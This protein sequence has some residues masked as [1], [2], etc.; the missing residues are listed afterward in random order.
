MIAA[1]VILIVNLGHFEGGRSLVNDVGYLLDVAFGAGVDE[2]GIP[3]GNFTSVAEG[4]G[5]ESGSDEESE[6]SEEHFEK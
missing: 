3:A 2:N 5:C 1:T 4:L 6:S